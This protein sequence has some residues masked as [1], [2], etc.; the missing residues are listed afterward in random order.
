MDNNIVQPNTKV[1]SASQTALLIFV[2]N[3]VIK[4]ETAT[5]AN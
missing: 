5:T 1:N 2:H 4:S 3:N